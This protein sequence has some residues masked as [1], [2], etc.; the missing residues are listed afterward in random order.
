GLFAGCSVGTFDA[1][2]Q[3]TLPPRDSYQRHTRLD[4]DYLSALVEALDADSAARTALRY[5]PNSSLYPAGGRLHYVEARMGVHGRSYH[6]VAVDETPELTRTLASATDSKTLAELAQA[7]VGDDVSF[8]EARE[9]MDEL[10]SS[11][12]VVSELALDVTGHEPMH[13]L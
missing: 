1:S 12:V 6:L 10:A 13:G 5:R 8:T 2:S 11:Q 7:L 4:M 3:L 9:F